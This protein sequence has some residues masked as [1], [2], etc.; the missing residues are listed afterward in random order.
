MRDSDTVVPTIL[1]RDKNR[2]ILFADLTDNYRI[3][4]ESSTFLQI[5]DK[6]SV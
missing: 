1:I 2:T 4:P 3:R 6:T 5:V